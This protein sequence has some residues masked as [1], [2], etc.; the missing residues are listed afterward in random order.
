MAD[1]NVLM[2]RIIRRCCKSFSST[3]PATES[4]SSH[5]FD[6]GKGLASVVMFAF[7]DVAEHALL[8]A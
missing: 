7:D 3:F 1:C 2:E 8:L 4:I 6:V 5:A